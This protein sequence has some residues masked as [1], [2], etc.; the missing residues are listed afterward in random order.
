MAFH[1][2]LIRAADRNGTPLPGAKVFT[3]RTGTDTPQAAYK[4]ATGSVPHA[5]P[6]VCNA[7]GLE[8]LWLD[9][10]VFNYRVRIESA[11][12][13]LVVFDRSDI[14][15]ENMSGILYDQDSDEFTRA[16]KGQLA[17]L[18]DLPS[19][20]PN[21]GDFY[22]I[23]ADSTLRV[24]NGTAFDNWGDTF[25]G[26]KALTIIG[27]A[28]LDLQQEGA[29]PTGA[30]DAGAIFNA[31]VLDGAKRIFIPPGTYDFDTPA[32]LV[33]GLMVDGNRELTILRQF[34]ANLFV[35]PNNLDG[36]QVTN[37]TADYRN[38]TPN[39]RHC[40]FKLKSHRAC[41]FA[42]INTIRY[43]PCTIFERMPDANDTI[44]TIYNVY[45]DF[46]I[47]ACLVV[48]FAA[49]WDAPRFVFDGDDSSTSI[50]C[51]TPWPEQFKSSLVVLRET[52]LR[53]LV[54]VNPSTLTV[55]YDG[56]NRPTIGLPFTAQVGDRFWVLPAIP[57]ASGRIPISNN[58]WRNIKAT[59]VFSRGHLAWRWL[60]AEAY[61]DEKMFLAQDFAI[62]WETNPYLTRG[63]QGGDQNLYR[64]CIGTYRTEMPQLTDKDTTRMFK[65]GP[66]SVSMSGESLIADLNW[67]N[68][69]GL[70]HT[71]EVIDRRLVDL[72]GTVST[73]SGS[74]TVTG[75]GTK[76]REE[77][78]RMGGNPD[79]IRI[80]GVNYGIQSIASDTQLTLSTTAASTLSDVTAQRRNVWSSSGV[81]MHWCN[82]GASLGLSDRGAQG[83]RHR[84][85][86][87]AFDFG[88]ATIVAGETFVEVFHECWRAPKPYEISV[89]AT[90][91]YGGR[92]VS[93]SNITDTSFR[94]NINSAG[95]SNFG[96]SWRIEL[97]DLN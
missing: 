87:D 60:D 73:T 9:D 71:I 25:S 56:S 48:D 16:Y 37:I 36:C 53:V 58:V 61:D 59:Y 57:A 33:S 75:S 84:T 28:W 17:T 95:G 4:D 24:W 68:D 55:S 65:F 29:S 26:S 11:D 22:F 27:R 80:D 10:S 97:I 79:Q 1:P 49:G 64:G 78:S 32:N 74:A 52:A 96:F 31:A 12:A 3:Y 13:S 92:S 34:G 72:T 39:P 42:R 69:S 91:V 44:N 70:L 63:A 35:G 67:R 2:L 6:V 83:G 19:S 76:F 85:R 88:T 8:V 94:I 89:T 38:P 47:S 81:D 54:E 50:V 5:N 51:D 62:G 20:A 45:E 90:S 14:D 21:V 40:L 43:D 15:P 93:I 82:L 7:N 66:G 18:D 30:N 86:S 23:A 46:D 41:T 77:L